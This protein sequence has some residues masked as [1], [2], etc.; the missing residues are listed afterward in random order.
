MRLRC[1]LPLLFAAPLLAQDDGV[2]EGRR[3]LLRLVDAHQKLAQF[4]ADYTQFR[5]TPLTKKPLQSSGVLAFRRTPGCVV[6]RVSAP[7]ET[8]IRL[9]TKV[10][11]VWRPEHKRLERFILASDEMPRL[12][13]DALAPTAEGLEKGFTVAGSAP[14]EVAEDQP[15]RRTVTLVPSDAATKQVAQKITLTIEVESGKLCGF[16]YRDP[17]GD[18]VRIELGALQIAREADAKLFEI[19]VPA[20]AK[21]VEQRVPPPE[22]KG[23]AKTEAK[24]GDKPPGAA[25]ATRK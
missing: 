20:D 7:K 14:V 2:E 22:S 8:V 12:L 9:D 13:F 5:S 16:G 19:A 21:V 25:A 11:E 10:Y 3:L 15:A 6:F 17:R 4:T 1:A 24:A 23:D 18:E